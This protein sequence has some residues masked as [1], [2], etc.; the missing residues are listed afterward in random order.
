MRAQRSIAGT[1]GATHVKFG[2]T[3]VTCE[4]TQESF[5]RTENRAKRANSDRIGVTCA[6][7]VAI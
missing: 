3:A 7:T 1:F 4:A 5:D 2:P 6:V